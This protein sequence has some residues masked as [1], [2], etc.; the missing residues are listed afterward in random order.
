[1]SDYKG[2]M[3]D[4]TEMEKREALHE[5]MFDY[6]MKIGIL[7]GSRKWGG[8]KQDS[9]YDLVIGEKRYSEILIH[10]KNQ[11]IQLKIESNEGSS[12]FVENTMYN[13]IND[14]FTL[15]FGKKNYLMNILTYHERDLPKIL[16]LNDI[17]DAM[18]QDSCIKK[19]I[20]EDK[21]KRIALIETLLALMFEDDL[22]AVNFYNPDDEIPF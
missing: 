16:E 2:L 13:I 7:I 22:K 21:D 17:L 14:K 12:D 20:I 19:R 5:K 18:P 1:M 8:A 4:I 6:F 3:N 11:S 9:D 10:I 15:S